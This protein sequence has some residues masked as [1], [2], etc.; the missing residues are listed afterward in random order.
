MICVRFGMGNR[1]T[2]TLGPA[3]SYLL[4][5][6]ALC[7]GPVWHVAA[8]YREH[9]W[10]VQGRRFVRFEFIG[11]GMTLADFDRAQGG[12]AGRF[13]PF[14]AV[15]VADGVLFADDRPFAKLV[16]EASVWSILET[17]TRLRNILI[18]P[19]RAVGRDSRRDGPTIL[20]RPQSNDEVD[21]GPTS[22]R[23]EQPL[24]GRPIRPTQTTRMGEASSP[25]EQAP[26]ESAPSPWSRPDAQRRGAG[27]GLRRTPPAIAR[28]SPQRLRGHEELVAAYVREKEAGPRRIEP[29]PPPRGVGELLR[30]VAEQQTH[31]QFGPLTPFQQPDARSSRATLRLETPSDL[32]SSSIRKTVPSC[33]MNSRFAR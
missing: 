7:I 20:D 4:S 31:G 21:L 13:G 26:G 1:D 18:E 8:V 17:E 22:G 19:D 33:H 9:A 32:A 12:Q 29:P 27:G 6:D 30:R 24:P 15:F 11:E 14:D 23:H 16:E 28:P 25:T 5:G 3:P 10:E 2:I